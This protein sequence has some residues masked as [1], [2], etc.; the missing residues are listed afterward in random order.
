MSVVLSEMPMR[1]NRC[2]KN[3]KIVEK[4]VARLCF[5]WYSFTFLKLCVHSLITLNLNFIYFP[6]NL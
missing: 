6:T 1:K 5:F 2:A 3:L 4:E